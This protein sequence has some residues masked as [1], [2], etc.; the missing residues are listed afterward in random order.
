ME[1]SPMKANLIYADRRTNIKQ[2]GFSAKVLKRI[3]K[4]H[5]I[6]KKKYLQSKIL[7]ARE[8]IV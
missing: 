6:A 4:S 7:V 1:L 8:S 2:N 5:V 3:K